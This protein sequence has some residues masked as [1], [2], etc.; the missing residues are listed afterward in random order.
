LT[1]IARGGFEANCL[2][3][4]TSKGFLRDGFE[5]RDRQQKLFVVVDA[6]VAGAA[7]Q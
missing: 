1:P 5:A 7:G 2:R 6:A 4:Q 3:Q